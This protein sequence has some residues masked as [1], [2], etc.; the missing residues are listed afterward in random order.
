MFDSISEVFSAL[1]GFSYGGV[2]LLSIA[3][4]AIVAFG[5]SLLIRGNKK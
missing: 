4:V 1:G 2:S 5:I 3:I